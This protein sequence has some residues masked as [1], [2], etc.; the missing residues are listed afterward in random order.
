[1]KGFAPEWWDSTCKMKVIFAAAEGM[2]YLHS[3][4]IIHRDFKPD[5]LLL[6][7]DFEA[8]ITDFGLSKRIDTTDPSKMSTFQVGTLNFMAPEMLTKDSYGISVDVY[9]FGITLY[10]IAS[11]TIPYMGL[12]RQEV[13]RH[14]AEHILPDFSNEGLPESI[15]QLISDCT[16]LEPSNRPTFRQIV[17]RLKDV[18]SI[19]LEDVDLDQY[20]D[21]IEQVCPTQDSSASATLQDRADHGDIE[22]ILEYAHCLKHGANGVMK[23]VVLSGYYLKM[24]ADRG[25]S[26]AQ[27]KYG[28]MLYLQGD[29]ATAAEY[30]KL[31]SKEDP[32]AARKYGFML[33]QG[34]GIAVNLKQGLDY[35]RSAMCK[36]DVKA[37]INFAKMAKSFGPDI[38]QQD[39]EVIVREYTRVAE[40]PDPKLAVSAN[41][42]RKLS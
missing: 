36:G 31:A 38:S 18:D 21:Y 1:M 33:I 11:G 28:N 17:E 14:V 20:R 40:G 19:H 13:T 9:S 25:N 7:D 22:A 34:Q 12:S 37:L 27:R 15:V 35:F 4:G 16:Q 29:Y 5:N 23:D 3:N 32:K 10:A 2:R 8:V 26:K 30:L 41:L 6:N 39:K 24:A 42:R